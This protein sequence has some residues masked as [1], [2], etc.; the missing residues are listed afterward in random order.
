MFSVSPVR[1]TLLLVTMTL[2]GL[3][4]SANEHGCTPNDSAAAFATDASLLTRTGVLS[5]MP[6][7]SVEFSK[8]LPRTEIQKRNLPPIVSGNTTFPLSQISALIHRL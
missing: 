8:K 6:G 3:L 4:M 2:G 5:V 7:E 1:I